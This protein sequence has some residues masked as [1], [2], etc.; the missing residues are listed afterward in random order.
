[1]I[2]LFT[3]LFHAGPRETVAASIPT[4]KNTTGL[5]LLLNL[6]NVAGLSVSAK[7]AR[8]GIWY[9]PL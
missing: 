6:A 3:R 7:L 5:V 1:M 4:V 8:D 2:G 9:A